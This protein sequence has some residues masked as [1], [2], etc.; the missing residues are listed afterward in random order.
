MST[1]LGATKSYIVL[2]SNCQHLV[3]Y[4]WHIHNTG[5]LERAEILMLWAAG[6]VSKR[7]DD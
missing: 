7:L 4:I 1:L 6:N 2:S 5:I 3:M